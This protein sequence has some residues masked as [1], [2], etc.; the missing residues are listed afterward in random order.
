MSLLLRKDVTWLLNFWTNRL[1]MKTSILRKTKEIK[2]MDSK[3]WNGQ[4]V[5]IYLLIHPQ[6]KQN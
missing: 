4:Q 6:A 2:K 5:D 3:E 1:K